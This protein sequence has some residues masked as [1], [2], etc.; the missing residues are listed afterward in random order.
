[1]LAETWNR[2]VA[3]WNARN[4]PLVFGDEKSQSRASAP[5]FA[6]RPAALASGLKN[7]RS[8]LSDG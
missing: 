4:I 6:Q 1:L 5:G 3:E 7:L 8:Q 2:A